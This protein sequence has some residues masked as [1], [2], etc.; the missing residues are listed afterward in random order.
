M[1][2]SLKEELLY[3]A[4]GRSLIQLLLHIAILMF[5]TKRKHILKA[6]PYSSLK[7]A[8]KHLK[9]SFKI[10]NQF[11]QAINSMKIEGT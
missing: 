11:T 1:C 6:W 7:P 3:L 2:D 4:V 5:F 10:E 8:E 9:H